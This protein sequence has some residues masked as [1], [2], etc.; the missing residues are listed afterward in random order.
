MNCLVQVSIQGWEPP[1]ASME[2]DWRLLRNQSSKL[3]SSQG[4]HVVCIKKWWISN[5]SY[6]SRRLNFSNNS[7]KTPFLGVQLQ[8]FQEVSILNKQGHSTKIILCNSNKKMRQ[9][10]QWP[11]L[12]KIKLQMRTYLRTLRVKK[13][14]TIHRK[15][16][17]LIPREEKIQ[18]QSK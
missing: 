17:S 8:L 12:R 1:L 16:G 9:W 5:R 2:N 3:S 7:F 13:N 11:K 10:K 6:H 18:A 14:L 4:N 15:E